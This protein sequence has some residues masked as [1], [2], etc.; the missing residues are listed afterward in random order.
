MKRIALAALPIAAAACGHP[1]TTAASQPSPA[2]FDA[3]KS[4]PK[5]LATADAGLAALGGYDK[6]QAVKE[7]RFELKYQ[8]SG[9]VQGWFQHRW[10][11]W[12]GRHDFITADPASLAAGADDPSKV[13]WL[14]VKYDLFDNDK[15]P[16]ASGPG[17]ELSAEDAAKYAT[18]ARERLAQDSYLP[19]IFYKLR[20]PGVHLADGG[21]ITADIANAT[22]LC[23]PSCHTVKITFEPE[24]GKDTWQVDYNA[25]T[26][27]PQL[28][29]KIVPEGH[30]A[31][32]I[33]GWADAGGLKFPLKLINV[34]IPDEIF[35][36]GEYGVG[37]PDD[38]YYAPPVDR[39]QGNST[40]SAGKPDPHP[41]MKQPDAPS[42]PK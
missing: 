18:I 33:D 29:E 38:S 21:D 8:K 17:G 36:Y 27:L 12:N 25:D 24:V 37:E 28:V 20:D 9:A 15:L 34:G 5:A 35:A 3:S 23:K 31:Y 26:H 10:D 2:A 22:D 14:D 42:N 11:R 40:K 19:L 41:T 4:D 6:W 13:R 32:R 39:S 1:R 30:I 16:Y 7:L